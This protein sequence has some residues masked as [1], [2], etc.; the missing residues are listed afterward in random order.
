MFYKLGKRFRHSL[1][2]KY[3]K[4]FRKKRSR[5]RNNGGN[6]DIMP[7]N[8]RNPVGINNKEFKEIKTEIG[9]RQGCVLSPLL[10]VKVMNDTIKHLKKNKERNG[11][12]MKIEYWKMEEIKIDQIIYVA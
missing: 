10:F 1:R 6:K 2:E 4:D 8:N 9:V 12:I 7:R 3:M 5:H 11:K